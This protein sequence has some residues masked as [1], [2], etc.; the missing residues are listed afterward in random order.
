MEK[1]QFPPITVVTPCWTD[2]LAVVS[3]RSWAS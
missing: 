2:G 3:H 1:P